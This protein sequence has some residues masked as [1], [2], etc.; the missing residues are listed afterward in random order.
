MADQIGVPVQF[1]SHRNCITNDLYSTPCLLG[2]IPEMRMC[3][4]PSHYVVDREFW[5][6]MFAR[7]MGLITRILQRSDSFQGRV[8][9]V[10][11]SSYNSIFHKIKNGRSCSKA[12]GMRASKTGVNVATAITFF[13]E[14]GFHLN[15]L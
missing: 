12:G 7:D 5:F 4:G 15:M 3:A 9:A 2:A 8:A 13:C 11:T 14:L 10:S 1:E 6:P